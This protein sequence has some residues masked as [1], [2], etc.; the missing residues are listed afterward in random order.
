MVDNLA[1][2]PRR[3]PR[4]LGRRTWGR[5]DEVSF[6]TGRDERVRPPDHYVNQMR[7][8]MGPDPKSVDPDS[9]ET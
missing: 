5:E 1:E 7:A 2:K 9:L 4:A 8:L 6:L 3:G